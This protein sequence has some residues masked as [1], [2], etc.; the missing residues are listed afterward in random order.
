MFTLCL[1]A[2]RLSGWRSA[3]QADFKP[4]SGAWRS[5]IHTPGHAAS[6]SFLISRANPTLR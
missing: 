2:L 3:Q 1:M 4:A 5:V 6:S